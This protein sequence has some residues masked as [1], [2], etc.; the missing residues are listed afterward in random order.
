VFYT[1]TGY[2]GMGP[3]STDVGDEVCILEGGKVPY[4]IRS[5]LAKDAPVRE[6][7]LVG[8]CYVSGVMKGEFVENGK[9]G[10]LQD[11]ARTLV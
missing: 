3:A 1:D 4:M 11:V 10:G 9:A 2:I 7:N 6:W 8:E 5:V